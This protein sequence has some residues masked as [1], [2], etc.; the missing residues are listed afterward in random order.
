MQGCESF[1]ISYSDNI[2]VFS[3][4]PEEHL[5]HL[6]KTLACL[7]KYGWKIS[8]NKSHIMATE[9]IVLFG[10]KLNLENG[11]LEPDPDKIIKI[12]EMQAPRDR[13]GI[14][15]FLGSLIYYADLIPDLTKDLATLQELLKTTVNYKWLEVHEKAFEN[16][17]EKLASPNF[18]ILPD[19]NKTFH[20]YVDA[21]PNYIGGGI[22]QHAPKIKGLLPVAYFSKKLSTL[23]VRYSQI[24]KEA[25]ALVAILKT[26][27]HILL[28]GYSIIHTDAKSLT[29][30]KCYEGNNKLMWWNMFIQ[31]F[32]HSI[33]WSSRK[34]PLSKLADMLSRQEVFNT[35]KINCLVVETSA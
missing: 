8:A 11:T 35:G 6:D 17:K 31:S 30:L 12:K 9:N 23:E 16:I 10:F 29:Y 26:H 32:P 4:T 18:V 27:A 19:Y 28:H 1:A 7:E 3:K 5:E 34:E 21:G 33:Q 2:L 24:E 13:K 20:I 15:R 22:Y 25:L 14:R